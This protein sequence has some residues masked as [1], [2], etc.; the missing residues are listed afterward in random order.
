MK[1]LLEHGADP[2][3][4]NQAK[5]LSPAEGAHRGFEE[6]CR[7]F[8]RTHGEERAQLGERIKQYEVL[9]QLLETAARRLGES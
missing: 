5:K 4:T 2:R 3:L 6:A 8:H 7:Q 1:F 9:V